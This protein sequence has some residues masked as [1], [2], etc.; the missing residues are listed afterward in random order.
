MW[1]IVF[2]VLF[3]VQDKRIILASIL[4]AGIVQGVESYFDYKV[5]I[6][7]QDVI[8]KSGINANDLLK[9]VIYRRSFKKRYYSVINK[10]VLDEDYLLINNF[11]ISHLLLRFTRFVTLLHGSD[12]RSYHS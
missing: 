4:I 10:L 11:I 3:F 2:L 5:K 12:N 8:A 7:Y 1:S 9:K 6:G